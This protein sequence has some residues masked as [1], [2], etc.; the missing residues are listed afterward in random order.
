[1]LTPVDAVARYAKSGDVHI[2][3]QVVGDGPRDLVFVPGWASHLELA[4]E[5]PRFARFLERLAS[6]SRL[7]RFDKRGTGLSDP[8]AEAPTLEERMDDLGAVMDAAGSE[9]AFIFGECEGGPLAV[10]FA[11]THPERTQGVAIYGTM[12][13]VGVDEGGTGERAVEEFFAGLAR[14]VERWGEGDSVDLFGPSVAADARVRQAHGAFE[15]A[16]ASPG[17]ACALLAR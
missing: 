4:W 17:M 6:F 9:R 13:G 7:I 15:R 5:H 8:V 14:V 3:Y 11:A 10:L 2:A 12:P 16:A 1:M